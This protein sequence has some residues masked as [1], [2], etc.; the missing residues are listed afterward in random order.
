MTCR[1]LTQTAPCGGVTAVDIRFSYSLST[2]YLF[3]FNANL[4]VFQRRAM[5]ILLHV[6][7]PYG[8]D[9]LLEYVQRQVD[10]GDAPPELSR[11]A[12]VIPALR[13]AVTIIHRCHLALFYLRGVFYHLAK[14]LVAT[15][16]V[17]IR[18]S[19][20]SDASFRPVFF[21]FLVSFCSLFLLG[22]CR[23][24]GDKTSI[25]L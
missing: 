6:A 19:R 14:R 13:H 25:K 4:A 17:S 23:N 5:M 2:D 15:R 1:G 22:Q 12:S 9:R 3:C 11:M 10:R 7:V 8:I 24:F 21:F 18:D 16:Y 20:A